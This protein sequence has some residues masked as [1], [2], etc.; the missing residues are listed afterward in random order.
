MPKV[1]TRLPNIFKGRQ[2]LSTKKM[3]FVLT[4][5]MYF[6]ES[7]TLELLYVNGTVG[8]LTTKVNQVRKLGQKRRFLTT[9]TL[10]LSFFFFQGLILI[11]GL[12]QPELLEACG[13]FSP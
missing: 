3:F 12:P 4:V 2:T 8:S 11:Q 9:N 1:I 13:G 10:F 7:N 6:E 5:P